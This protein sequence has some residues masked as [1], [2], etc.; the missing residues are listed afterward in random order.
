MKTS[1][2]PANPEP[3]SV[4]TARGCVAT[5]LT[6]PGFGSLMA[7]RRSGYLQSV[8]TVAGFALTVWFGMRFMIWFFKNTEAIFGA[9]ADPIQTMTDLWFAV[10][11]ALLGIALFTVSWLWSLATNAAILRSARK[12]DTMDK[13]PILT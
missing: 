2:A 1:S 8:L 11:W 5:N 4:Q 3:L 6:L 12:A 9:Q 7:R 13:P 10:R